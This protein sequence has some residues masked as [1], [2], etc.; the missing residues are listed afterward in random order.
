M[1]K[2]A[3][4][5]SEPN[6]VILIPAFNEEE[7]LGAVLASIRAHC[8]FPVVVV[9]DC[10]R[11]RTR[12]I[13]EAAGATVLPL[14]VQLG[15]W[16]ATQTG[17]RYAMRSG[18]DYAI[19]MDADGQHEAE[20]LSRVLAPVLAGEADVA[21]GACTERGS[22]A[23]HIAWGMMKRTSGL[24]LKDLTSGFR[25][26]NRSAIRVLASWRATLLDYQDV[27]VLLLL[28]SCG[29]RIADVEVR[30]QPRI[31]GASR[32]FYSWMMVGYYMVH[33]LLLGVTKRKIRA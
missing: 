21:I 2:H 20:E 32:V 33:T 18:F 11:D 13:A 12:E 1:Q 4:A 15:A 10:S 14:S 31:N 22:F 28:Q 9:D 29:I 25:V 8:N 5:S 30:M 17:M 26:C 19:C 16:G 27:G 23:R 24:S 6:A 3:T 7:S